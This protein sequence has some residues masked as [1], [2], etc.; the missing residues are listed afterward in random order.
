M[1]DIAKELDVLNNNAE[2]TLEL[3]IHDPSVIK[4]LNQYVSPQREEKANEALKVGVIAILS[5]TPSLDTKVVEEKFNE[6]ESKLKIHAETF[7]RD[8]STD[9]RKYLEKEKGDLPLTLNAFF[10]E[11]GKLGEALKRYFDPEN[12]KISSLLKK[13]LGPGSAFLTSLDPANKESVISKIEE[14]VKNKLSD[15]VNDLIDQF[16]LDKENS[17]MSRVKNLFENKVNEI[18]SANEAFFSE[19]KTH[20]GMQAARAEEAEKGTQKGRDFE[21][22]LYEKFAF[23]GQ[24]L[25]DTTD[26]LTGMIGKIQRCKVGDYKSTL[27]ETSGAP[28]KSIVVEV[29]NEQGYKMRD[30]IQELKEAK[31]NRETDCGIFVFAKGCEPI[32]MNDFKIDGNDF[33]CT[34]SLQALERG[35][36]LLFLEA[37]YKIARINIITQLREETKDGVDLNAVK[38]NVDKMMEKAQSM[39]EVLT[40]AK[41]IQA[42]G[43]AI[44]KIAKS[45]KD[46][47]ESII[48]STLQLLK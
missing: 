5:A 42:S 2:L 36:Q 43:E 11:Q 46:E 15:V 14:V 29:K 10:G 20:V 31:E 35:D 9:L 24:Q 47:L 18:K 30:A 7:K 12:G 19:F 34:V 33:Y 6:I 4:Y 13:E 48:Q 40:K 25:Q 22:S 8:L 21:T 26:N 3:I 1:E 27:G 38:I 23:L 32:E 44:E 41:T 45:I 16:S 28:G 39:S 17:G 37:A